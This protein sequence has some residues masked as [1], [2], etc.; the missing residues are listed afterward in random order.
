MANLSWLERIPSAK[1]SVTS[2]RAG[3][4]PK[5]PRAQPKSKPEVAP[6]Y[7]DDGG[8]ATD[9]AEDPWWYN[10]SARK[11]SPMERAPQYTDSGT[12]PGNAPSAAWIQAIQNGTL[13]PIDPPSG[14][15]DVPSDPQDQGSGLP[16]PN[17]FWSAPTPDPSYAQ[18]PDSEPNPTTAE[19][20][21]VGGRPS[22]QR[23]A[24][25][26]ADQQDDTPIHGTP[27]SPGGAM[28]GSSPSSV[29]RYKQLL[30][31][32]PENKPPSW[33]QRAAGAA[34]GFGAGM[35]NA[36]HIRRPIDIN[37]FRQNFLSPGYDAKLED[38]LSKAQ[39][40]Q[41]LVGL[42][43]AQRKAQLDA[44]KTQS[45]ADYRKA[46]GDY[47]EAHA[48]S[49]TAPGRNMVEV[50]PEMETASHGLLKRG[51][52]IGQQDLKELVHD[53]MVAPTPA[54]VQTVKIL[55]DEF[56]KA[57]GQPVGSEVP[58]AVYEQ[59]LKN[60][61]TANPTKWGAYIQA[62][63]GDPQKALQMA[64]QDAISTHNQER[65]PM[66]EALAVDRLQENKAKANDA[67][68]QRKLADE[69]MAFQQYQSVANNPGTTPELKNQAQLRYIQQLQA[70]QDNY[71]RSIRNRGGS[72]QDLDVI[73]S[74]TGVQ[75]VPRGQKPPTGGTPPPATPPA[76]YKEGQTATNAKGQKIVFR[77]GKW[78]PQ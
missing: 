23:A 7:M 36:G 31:E 51:T 78:V 19:T 54:K 34:A 44:Q 61:K 76:K 77:G 66:A 27:N 63:G 74:P 2:L 42:E 52:M 3:Q 38:W 46:M 15:A 10:Q 32:F 72:A 35:A 37:S 59:G 62:A 21:L 13:P 9:V 73:T 26:D 28:P 20:P 39:P 71:S 70:A 53:T 11:E 40:A 58:T 6:N 56:S 48:K 8:I 65:N 45:E 5:H 24:E 50:T 68:D 47:A 25:P 43:A 57:L 12:T 29:D 17:G 1:P 55:T 22:I 64:K 16:F 69:R 49:L 67:I 41:S 75:Y 18:D 14:P 4:W 30:N 60:M 33:W